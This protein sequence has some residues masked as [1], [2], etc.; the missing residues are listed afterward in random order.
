MTIH[1]IVA[2]YYGEANDTGGGTMKKIP[3][4]RLHEESKKIGIVYNENKQTQQE[5][6][7]E[8]IFKFFLGVLLKP[9]GASF[10]AQRK[11]IKREIIFKLLEQVQFILKNRRLSCI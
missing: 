11:P 4:E 8:S 10:S 1:V 9:G 5:H 2:D 7:N 6:L 3:V